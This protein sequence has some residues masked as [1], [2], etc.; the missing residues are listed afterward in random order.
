[1]NALK[2]DIACIGM[3]EDETIANSIG[4]HD[5]DFGEPQ[6]NHRADSRLPPLD[7]F[8][9]CYKIPLVAVQHRRREYRSTTREI[10]QVLDNG[11]M[12]RQNRSHRSGRA[13]CFHR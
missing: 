8:T 11:E 10:P 3:S 1:M 6:S 4:N 13:V 12:W 5:F 9:E 7:T 2:V